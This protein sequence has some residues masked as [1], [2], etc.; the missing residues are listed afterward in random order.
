MIDYV[1][2]NEQFR[3]GH[4]A[5]WNGFMFQGTDPEKR[6]LKTYC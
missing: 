2:I 5:L 3:L 1:L 6:R 4:K